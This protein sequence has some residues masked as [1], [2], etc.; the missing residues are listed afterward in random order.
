M[1]RRITGIVAGIILALGAVSGV[2]LPATVAQAQSSQVCDISLAC[3]NAWN[4]GPYVNTYGPNVANDNFHIQ[5]INGRCRAGSDLTTAGC[6]YAG[7]PAG[8]LIVQIQYLN[9]PGDCLGDLNGQSGSARAS[10]F[11]A[12]NSTSSGSGGSYGTVFFE[13]VPS[14]GCPPGHFQLYSFHWQNGGLNYPGAGNGQPW[15]LNTT[16]PDCVQQ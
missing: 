13:N 3:L 7:V 4:G 6:P 15:Y 11:D 2:W 10:A 16:T 12:C 14:F 5:P 8:H 9:H 1:H